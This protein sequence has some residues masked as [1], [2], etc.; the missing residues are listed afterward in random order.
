MRIAMIS[1]PFVSVPP[2]TYG[3]TEFI[4]H[5]LVEGLVDA[6]HEVT[7][8]ATGDS[9]TRGEL[10]FLYAGPQW[11]PEPLAELNHVSWAMGEVAAGDFD[12]IHAHSALAL[13]MSRLL[14]NPPL[15]YTIH[16]TL[17]VEFSDF[18]RY[19]PEAQYIAISHRQRRLE[20]PLPRCTVIHHGI[21]PRQ[22]ECGEPED[23]VCFVARLSEIKGPHIAI[24]AARKT[25]VPIRVAGE[26]HAPD[27]EFFRRE[28]EAR[29]QLPHVT[30]L[31]GIGLEQKR[32]LL[33]GARALLAPIDWEEPFGLFMIEA[34]LSGCPVV[35][36]SRGS[37]PELVEPGVTGF[38]VSSAGE[39][40]EAIRVGGPVDAFDRLRCRS[41]AAERF[42]RSRLVADH[43]H[44]Y[45]N[46]TAARALSADFV[47]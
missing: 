13:G 39:M 22:F 42:S 7:L 43:L 3:G 21:D 16:H 41:R 26:A 35:A 10:R 29:L 37:V 47:S 5:E 20:V 34:M 45:R 4:V 19:F 36:F 31:G 9:R 33:R 17:T 25:G 32:S 1:T 38:I 14:P 8:F 18:Y 24:D 30:Y 27:R 46:V 44:L 28:V 2:A 12:L 6:G 11:P 15:V 40:A 23:Y